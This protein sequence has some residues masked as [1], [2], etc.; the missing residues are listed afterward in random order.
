MPALEEAIA[1]GIVEELPS[2]KPGY[3]FTH[4]LVRRSLY[5]ALPPVRRAE[6]HLQV[7]EAQERAG[8]RSVADLAHHFAAAAPFGGAARGVEYNVLAAREASAGLDFDAAADRLRVA[9]DLGVESPEA[10]AALLLELGEARHR[11]GRAGEALAAFAEAAEV[12]TGL[13]DAE[14]LARAAIGYETACWRPVITD[15]LAVELLERAAAALDDEPSQLRIGVL[16]GLARALS[17]R[18]GHARGALVRDSAIEMARR[19]DDRAALAS[20]LSGSYWDRGTRSTNEILVMLTEA[21]DLAEELGDV[22]LQCDASSWRVS[23]LVALCDIEA[24]RRETAAAHATAERTTQPFHL[25][26]AE[27]SGS[28][29]ALCQGRL[30]DAEAMAER[31]HEWSRLLTGRDA[32][33]V[34]GIQMFGL[35]REQGRLA[36]LA[37][38][39]RV[40]AVNADAWRPGLALLLSELGMEA[41]ARRELAR[42]A[43]DGLD[44]FRASLWLASLSYL[45]EACAELGDEGTAALL[46]P[47]LAFYEGT[48]V[49]IGH[50]VACHG[51]ADRLLGMLA[52]TLGDWDRAEQHFERAMALNRVMGARTWLAHTA[53][54]YGRM[55]LRRGLDGSQLLGEAERLATEIGLHALLHRVRSLGAPRVVAGP[56]DGLSFREVQVLG[57]VANGLSNREVGAALFISEHTAANHIRSILRKTNCANRT[58]A[59]SYAHKHGL[60]E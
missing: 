37:P 50:V 52:S 16:G 24:A 49:M 7:G 53:Y 8:V 44:R 57:L 2:R 18:G 39:I 46:Y 1:S 54:E 45:A 55:Q 30:G 12:A 25:H 47:E 58:E 21:R 20:V 43:A 40:L 32:S 28:A 11:A 29:I 59:T 34:Y 17:I 36:E 48:N 19:I 60:V 9:L 31:S 27:H 5:D 3:R 42:V 13:G 10:R 23:A 15:A 22:E 26:V 33:G 51:A 14:L 41:E 35:R 6:L 38:V 56:P 4:E